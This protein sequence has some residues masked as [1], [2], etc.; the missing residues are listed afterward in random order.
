MVEMG[1]RKHGPFDPRY[2]RPSARADSP[3]VAPSEECDSLDT[4]EGE[5]GQVDP[6]PRRA[7]RGNGLRPF[8]V[9]RA[10]RRAELG[11][12]LCARLSHH[13]EALLSCD[14][15]V[16]PLPRRRSLEA[17]NNR[18]CCGWSRR[19]CIEHTAGRAR[20]RLDARTG[21]SSRGAG[22]STGDLSG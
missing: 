11:R 19:H 6:H 7:G 1:T 8:Q 13:E 12:L 4:W 3:Q 21:Q 20:F 16:V 15:D 5:G 14:R 9:G 22:A 10:S 18:A 17:A 2:P